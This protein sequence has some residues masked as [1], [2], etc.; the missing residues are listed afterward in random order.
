MW[1]GIISLFPKMF[2][3]IKNYGITRQGIKKKLLQLDFCNPRDY[4]NNK[5][6]IDAPIYGGG[7]IILKPEPLMKAIKEIKKKT[8]SKNIKVIYLSPQGKNINIKYIKTLL[9]YDFILICGRY[10]GIDERVIQYFID[11]EIS[12]GDYILSGGELPAMIVIDAVSRLIPGVLNNIASNKTDSFYNNGL[13]DCP[14]YTR[15]AIITNY[16]HVPDILL[17]G[18]HKKINDWK[19]QNSLG[20]TWLKRPDLLNKKKLNEKEKHLLKIFKKNFFNIK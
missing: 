18:N 11:E 19:L 9:K 20:Y 15:P 7:G 13:L 2:D 5:Y 16:S 10:K 3:A 1:I 4:V 17:S 12:I 8:K 6:K 14:H